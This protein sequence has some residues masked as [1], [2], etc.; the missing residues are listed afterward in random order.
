MARLTRTDLEKMLEQAHLSAKKLNEEIDK[1]CRDNDGL[2]RRIWSLA[3]A[4]E[5]WRGLYQQQRRQIDLL[6]ERER[7]TAKI[8]VLGEEIDRLSIKMPASEVVTKQ[9]TD[10]EQRR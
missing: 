10:A 2:H 7:L 3:K 1:L 6:A 4:C 9:A 8:F 5:D